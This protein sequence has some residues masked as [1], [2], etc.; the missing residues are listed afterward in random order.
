MSVKIVTKDIAILANNAQQKPV[1]QVS[2]TSQELWEV[3]VELGLR[4]NVLVLSFGFDLSTHY[5]HILNGITMW[6]HK[7]FLMNDSVMH[8]DI[9]GQSSHLAVLSTAIGDDPRNWKK[10]SGISWS[11]ERYIINTIAMW[12][13][14]SN[15]HWDIDKLLREQKKTKIN[16]SKIYKNF[17]NILC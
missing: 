16:N 6:I 11:C 10:I 1:K 3:R 7:I 2:H 17:K 14:I 5:F 4:N 15:H 13:W 8:I 9:I 12:K